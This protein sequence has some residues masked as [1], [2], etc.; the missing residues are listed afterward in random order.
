MTIGRFVERCPSWWTITPSGLHTTTRL[1]G[2]LDSSNGFQRAACRPQIHD[3]GKKAG[4]C[5][6][7]PSVAANV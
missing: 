3:L 4:W 5:C 6:D 1:M 2:V 7:P